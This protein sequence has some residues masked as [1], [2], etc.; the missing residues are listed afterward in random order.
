[1]A[2][3]CLCHD[4]AIRSGRI[5]HVF[6]VDHGLR[7]SA[8]AEAEAVAKVCADLG[9]AHSTLIWAHPKPTQ[10]AARQARYRLLCRAMQDIGASA[11]LVGHTFDDVVETALIRRRRGVRSASAA[12][13]VLA[14][15]APVWPD[16]RG[17]TLLRPLLFSSRATLREW[18]ESKTWSWV[19]DPSNEHDQFER[20]RVR[21][22]LSRHSCLASLA[23]SQVQRL[24]GERRDADHGISEKLARV[25]VAPDGLLS[26]DT[27]DISPR[28]M[29]VL[30]R[31]ASGSDRDPRA[32]AT[33]A[34]LAALR[35][36]GARQTLGGAWFQRTS[37][38]LKV[39]RDPG[40]DIKACGAGLFDGRYEV[41]PAD[42]LPQ[43]AKQAFL[44]RASSP[45]GRQ[46]RET[47]SD[48]LAHLVQC[49]QTPAL[50]PV[51]D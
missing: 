44:V 9:H 5:L 39:G 25:K 36:V 45:A 42:D 15:P 12:G 11:L 1:M 13:P 35:S 8:K 50:S 34:A 20:V 31:C 6:T 19:E 37:H 18:L 40:A 46:W 16:G 48:R 14:A 22:F 33:E 26:V 2:L 24:Q 10:M 43:K 23:H 28:V 4:W 3:L 30:A 17:I 27:A 47:I 38:G 32:G 29:A 41:S 51:L 7:A 21:Q 49:Y